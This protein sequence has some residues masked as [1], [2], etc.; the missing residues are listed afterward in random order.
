MRR[1]SACISPDATRDRPPWPATLW[2]VAALENGEAESLN[3]AVSPQA[4][5]PSKSHSEFRDT[6]V[7]FTF[8]CNGKC[9]R[10]GGESFTSPYRPT[11]FAPVTCQSCGHLTSVNNAL[12]PFPEGESGATPVLDRDK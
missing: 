2:P 5:G 11:D 7:P 9:P 10:C 3:S 4:A 8:T 12:H 1:I 6:P